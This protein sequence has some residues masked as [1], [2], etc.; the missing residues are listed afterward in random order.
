LDCHDPR[1][2]RPD[3]KAILR[4]SMGGSNKDICEQALQRANLSSPRSSVFVNFALRPVEPHPK[5]ISGPEII[6]PFWE[7]WLEKERQQMP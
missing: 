3:A 1:G 6:L 7:V 5:Q 4:F 2:S